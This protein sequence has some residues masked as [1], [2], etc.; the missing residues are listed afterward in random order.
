MRVRDDDASSVV[1]PS[2]RLGKTAG[3]AFI[4]HGCMRGSATIA[5]TRICK[6]RG[7]ISQPIEPTHTT[8]M[9]ALLWFVIGS[10]S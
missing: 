9:L 8:G 4:V 5:P 2:R 10:F 7:T 6:P 3:D 1:W